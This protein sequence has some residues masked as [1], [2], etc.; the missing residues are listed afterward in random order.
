MLPTPIP[1]LPQERGRKL[2]L[3]V[4]ETL[5]GGEPSQNIALRNLEPHTV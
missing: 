1:H 3:S 2:G 5:N 4:Q